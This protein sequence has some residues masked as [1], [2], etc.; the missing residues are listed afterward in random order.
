MVPGFRRAPRRLLLSLVCPLR[1]G[2]DIILEVHFLK[3]ADQRPS[4]FGTSILIGL[5]FVVMAT[6]AVMIWVPIAPCPRCSGSGVLSRYGPVTLDS[7]TVSGQ[8]VRRLTRKPIETSCPDCS[9]GG[10]VSVLR[11]MTFQP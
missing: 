10:R 8:P 9:H 4:G 2:V 1:P 7:T 5:L 11:K 6:V 3:M